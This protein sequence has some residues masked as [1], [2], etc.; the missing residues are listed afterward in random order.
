MKHIIIFISILFFANC[1]TIKKDMPAEKIAD[2]ISIKT[3]EAERDS[4]VILISESFELNGMLCHWE[5]TLVYSVGFV[6]NI[7]MNL[8]NST[9]NEVL[10][11]YDDWFKFEKDYFSENYFPEI[12]KE[13]F[14]DL[15]FDGFK[16]FYIKN[17][18]SMAMNDMTH[19]YIFNNETK[20]FEC[21]EELSDNSIGEL[22]SINKILHTG[23][24]G[25]MWSGD[26]Y[27]STKIHHFDEFGKLKFTEIL[28]EG[29]NMRDTIAIE[30]ETY[31]K[32]INDEVVEERYYLTSENER[33][34]SSE[35][36]Y[37]KKDF[38]PFDF[39]HYST[40]KLM[41]Y[42]YDGVTVDSLIFLE[43]IELGQS[44]H[45]IYTYKLEDSY[46]S[47]LVKDDDKYFYLWTSAEIKQ[48]M[49]KSKNDVR[50][51]IF[52]E[53]FYKKIKTSSKSYE[54]FTITE[55]GMTYQFD[56]KGGLLQSIYIEN[57]F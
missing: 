52:E 57:S 22:D 27:S 32:L 19:I 17:Y 39:Q 23:N 53:D 28:T 20:R 48:D 44:A 42:F 51:G 49:F 2:V 3:D 45:K 31:K 34:R 43:N 38:F 14:E 18:G 50:I 36:A 30:Y 15:N 11:E 16:D 10:L 25:W 29:I 5:H 24:F 54:R 21:S 55:G 41:S 46:I 12:N 26:G 1:S 9:T 7:I 6:N 4:S 56:F 33:Y 40:K 8:K 35:F 37:F 47:F 13:H